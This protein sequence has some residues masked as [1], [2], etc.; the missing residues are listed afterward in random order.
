MPFNSIYPCSTEQLFRS[1][2]LFFNARKERTL[3]PI[4]ANTNTTESAFSGK[5]LIDAIYK[6]GYN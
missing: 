4:V 6:D 2:R 1:G 3:F 5:S